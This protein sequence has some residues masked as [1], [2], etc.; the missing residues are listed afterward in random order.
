M[1]FSTIASE[2]TLSLC[3]SS[4]T[5]CGNSEEKKNIR[6]GQVWSYQMTG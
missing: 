4:G 2:T 3:M 1:L 6:H 5:S